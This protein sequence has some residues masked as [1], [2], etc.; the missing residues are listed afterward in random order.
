[1]C[2]CSDSAG[3]LGM[4]LV[5]MAREACSY[6]VRRDLSL[7]ALLVCTR[8][9]MEM[10]STSGMSIILTSSHWEKWALNPSD[11]QACK[12]TFLQLVNVQEIMYCPLMFL[13]K[14]SIL[15]LYLRIF[16]TSNKTRLAYVIHTVMA[17]T[18]GLYFAQFFVTLLGCIPRKKL[19]NPS[20]TGHCI[21]LNLALEFSGAFN[22]GADFLI[23]FLPLHSIWRLQMPFQRKIQ[24][25]AVFAFG[26]F[27]CVASIMRLV[28]QF[29]IAN[30]K[31]LTYAAFE[32]GLWT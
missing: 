2:T 17:A 31:D 18:F 30:A 12:L 15:L 26:L 25:S 11:D 23:L 32:V 20:V 7:I 5:D 29:H 10:A 13:T 9:N 27:A 22:V 16:S 8:R 28:K 24:V 4:V 6:S 14:A 3:G 19:W 21:N 1:M